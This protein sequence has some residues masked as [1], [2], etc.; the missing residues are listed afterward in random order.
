M[1]EVALDTHVE[2]DFHLLF[3]HF[4]RQPE[5]GYL[6]A[7]EAA[8]GRFF[9]EQMHFV[10]ERQKIPRDG[11]RRGAGPEQRD[12]FAILFLRYPGQVGADI[13]LVVRGNPL[14]AADRYRFLF[15][16]DSTACGFTGPVAGATENAGEHVGI[17]VEHVGFGVAFLGDEA[18]VLGN[19]R[20]SGTGPLTIHDL[21]KIIG[22]ENIRG[23]H[24]CGGGPTAALPASNSP[25]LT[26][27]SKTSC[28]GRKC[29]WQKRRL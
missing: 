28:P 15:R 5:S 2:D 27:N 10:A 22:V 20:V 25:P 11:Q 21:V 13:T 19:R 17:P 23:F 8:A 9:L 1:V 24:S 26:K 14:Q 18:D 4:D 6:R 12:A 7:H 3:E 29:P 16:S